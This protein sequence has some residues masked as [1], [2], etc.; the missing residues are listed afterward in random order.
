MTTI[1]HHEIY[2]EI[3]YTEGFWTGKKSLTINGCPLMKTGRNSFAFTDQNGNTFTAFLKGNTLKGV[4]L[5]IGGSEIA[6]TPKTKWYEILFAIIPL[7]F[8]I[9]WGN[10]VALCSIFPIVGGAIGG[11]ISGL[12]GALSLVFI[13]KTKNI[14][15]K[16]LIALGALVVCVYICYIIAVALLSALA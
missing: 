15:L 11:G 3:A 8:V 12:C 7:I 14:G 10:S 6:I 5:I 2:G 16:I 13:K 9:V 1:V 4:T